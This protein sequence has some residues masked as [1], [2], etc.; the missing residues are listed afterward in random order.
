M[1][2]TPNIRSPTF[3]FQ[4]GVKHSPEVAHLFSWIWRA[5]GAFCVVFFFFFLF[6][7]LSLFFFVLEKVTYM[8]TRGML[9]RASGLATSVVVFDLDVANF[10]SLSIA[11]RTTPTCGNYSL[12]ECIGAFVG[13]TNMRGIGAQ[14]RLPPIPNGVES[15]ILNSNAMTVS[16][17]RIE[18][19]PTTLNQLDMSVNLFDMIP[20]LPRQLPLLANV[21]ID[22]WK[23]LYCLFFCLSNP[24]I[25]QLHHMSWCWRFSRLWGSGSYSYVAQIE[26]GGHDFR[27]C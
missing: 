16:S 10:S 26:P 17:L 8:I 4:N 13:C 23:C 27:R 22:V 11:N 12:C 3:R 21:T 18:Q 9:N 2:P 25:V 14:A 5:S 1:I 24:H 19:L 6:V 20:R 15:L 7:C